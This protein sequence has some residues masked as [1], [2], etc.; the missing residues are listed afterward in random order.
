[1]SEADDSLVR[2]A[3]ATAAHGARI[4]FTTHGDHGEPLV[5]VAG[6]A[7]DHHAWQTVIE[8][9]SANHRLVLFD[10]RGVGQSDAVFPAT[11]STRDFARDVVSVL[12]AAD[13]DRAH[14]YGH[15]MGGRVAQWL[16]ADA[17]ERVA[18]L[19]LGGTSV[20]EAHGVRRPAEATKALTGTDMTALRAMFYTPEWI[21]RNPEQAGA[22]LPNARTPQALQAHLTAAM[23]HDGWDALPHIAAPTLVIH[24]GDDPVTLPGNATLLAEHIAGAELD[25]IDGARH[26]YWAGFP[27]A[28]AHIIDFLARHPTKVR[29]PQHS[30]R[31]VA[32]RDE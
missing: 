3:Y 4:W 23:G 21:E 22:V 6:T 19:V 24:G 28:N 18:A 31:P 8:E 30:R 10:H 2:M 29:T 17:P 11:W 32:V 27:E 13:V 20:G 1:M 12:D 9:F 15:S 25:I 7:L 16:A 5:L 26:V 14:V